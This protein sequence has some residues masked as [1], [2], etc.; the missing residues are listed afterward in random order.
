MEKIIVLDVSPNKRAQLTACQRWTLKTKWNRQAATNPRAVRQRRK[1]NENIED[2]QAVGDDQPALSRTDTFAKLTEATLEG[3]AT[4][5]GVGAGTGIFPGVAVAREAGG[6]EVSA[7]DAD[8]LPAE[9]SAAG[10]R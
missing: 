1:Q 8:D 2:R 3:E 9:P 7:N 4:R 5:K 10:S 6:G